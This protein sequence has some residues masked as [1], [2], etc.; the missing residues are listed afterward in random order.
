MLQYLMD[1]NWCA[2]E[3]KKG[4]VRPRI[5]HED[6]QREYSFFN[7]ATRWGWVV[8]ATPQLPYPWERDL[9]PIV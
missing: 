3:I 8:I 2:T 7:L 9:V 5:S 6:S 1:V 4:K